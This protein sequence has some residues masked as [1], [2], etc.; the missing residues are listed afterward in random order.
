MN[1][2]VW[3]L[4]TL[5]SRGV[6]PVLGVSMVHTA[7]HM[8]IASDQ[9]TTAQIANEKKLQDRRHLGEHDAGLHE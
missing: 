4:A 1:E 2:I 7:G 8:A 3:R 5:T 9:I 6:D